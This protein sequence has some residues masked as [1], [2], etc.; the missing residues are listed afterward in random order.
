[1]DR[2]LRNLDVIDDYL[3]ERQ[4]VLRKQGLSFVYTPGDNL[5]RFMLGAIFP[6]YVSVAVSLD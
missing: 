1:M 5:A 3:S 2:E 4:E 6:R